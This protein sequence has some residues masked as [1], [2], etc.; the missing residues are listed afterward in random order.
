MMEVVM[1]IFVVLI[2]TISVVVT[3]RILD[4][5]FEKN[6]AKQIEELRAKYK[7]DEEE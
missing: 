6:L 1:L 3:M 5:K 4:K 7:L 2:F